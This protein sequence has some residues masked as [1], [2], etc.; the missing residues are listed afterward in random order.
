M[1]G[2][3]IGRLK[4]RLLVA[5]IGILRDVEMVLHDGP[6]R[7]G[8]RLWDEVKYQSVL[9]AD[10]ERGTNAL[11]PFIHIASLKGFLSSQW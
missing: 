5:A 4:V 9:F 10:G 8:R 2:R 6:E 1:G 3:E 11:E 7:R